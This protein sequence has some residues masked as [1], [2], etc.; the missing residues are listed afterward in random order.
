MQS[1]AISALTIA[2]AVSYV[3][4]PYWGISD[5]RYFVLI[6]FIWQATQGK[7]PMTDRIGHL[8]PRTELF[9]PFDSASHNST[10]GMPLAEV[11]RA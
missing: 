7:T 4:L 10:T 8:F 1:V 11:R 2:C 5:P 3:T 6:T 9:D